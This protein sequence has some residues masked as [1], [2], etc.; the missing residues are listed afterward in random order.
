M[1]FKNKKAEAK[2]ISTS[3][4][5]NNIVSMSL[6]LAQKRQFQDLKEHSNIFYKSGHTSDFKYP[7]K[8][9]LKS[10]DTLTTIQDYIKN[11]EL[12]QKHSSKSRSTAGQQNIY[13]K[14]EQIN[15]QLKQ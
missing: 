8:T 9:L 7:P 11:K 2:H 4:R 15:R 13:Q 6:N 12:S 3:P 10:Q 14:F 1:I 5:G